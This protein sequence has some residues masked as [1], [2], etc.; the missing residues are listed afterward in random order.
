MPMIKFIKRLFPSKRPTHPAI[1]ANNL[2]SVVS[3]R[4]LP[5]RDCEFVVFDTELTGLKQRKDE[6]IAIGAVRIKKC[7]DLL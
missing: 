5:V 6:I 7:E 4:D 2:I 1:V 3:N